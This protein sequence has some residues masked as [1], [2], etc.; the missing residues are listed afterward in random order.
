MRSLFEVHGDL[1]AIAERIESIDG[2][3]KIYFNGEAHR[4]ELHHTRT[5]PTLQLLLGTRLDART[6]AKVYRTRVER[7]DSL[8]REIDRY[9]RFADERKDREIL[10]RAQERTQRILSCGD[11]LR[12]NRT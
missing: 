12:R 3:Y 9:N 11:D 8:E 6:I 10:E 1:F 7:I 5:R 2:D 4:Y